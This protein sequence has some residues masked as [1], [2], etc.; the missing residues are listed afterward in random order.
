[1]QLSDCIARVLELIEFKNILFKSQ[2]KM[3]DLVLVSVVEGMLYQEIFQDRDGCISDI[4]VVLQGNR[5]FSQKH[6]HQ[7]MVPAILIS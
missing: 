3:P 4:V 6:P 7:E 5:G 2:Q 1:M